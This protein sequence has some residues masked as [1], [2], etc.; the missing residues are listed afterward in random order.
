MARVCTALKSLVASI[1]ST[2]V[3]I[4][5]SKEKRTERLL[6]KQVDAVCS[7]APTLDSVLQPGNSQRLALTDPGGMPLPG[8][9][10]L[11]FCSPGYL[12]SQSS[13]GVG[14]PHTLPGSVR[15]KSTNQY[16]SCFPREMQFTTRAVTPEPDRSPSNRTTI[17][18]S[19]GRRHRT[20]QPCGFT[21][22]TRHD[23][24]NACV[25]SRLVRVIGISHGIRV[26]DR[27]TC[28]RRFKFHLQD[29]R[30]LAHCR[31]KIDLNK[32]AILLRLLLQ[33]A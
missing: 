24:E 15:D 23:S 25:G 28:L 19:S 31:P 16:S 32:E 5:T 4:R 30:M 2:S 22:I 6:W 8:K 9:S 27:E 17:S 26:L 10:I 21:R 13:G 11:S 29:R 14:T 1:C 20:V 12:M 7:Y 33:A 18:I 3:L